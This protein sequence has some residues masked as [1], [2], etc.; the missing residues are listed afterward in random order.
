M[1]TIE[2]FSVVA[3]M[4][5]ALTFVASIALALTGRYAFRVKARIF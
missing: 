3:A 2:T 4:Y 5:V 1:R